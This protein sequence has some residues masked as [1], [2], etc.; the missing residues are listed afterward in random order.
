MDAPLT[1]DEPATG[2]KTE[3]TQPKIRT[4]FFFMGSN[5]SEFSS[6]HNKFMHAALRAETRDIEWV[7]RHA[8]G[9]QEDSC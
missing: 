5:G 8:E 7:R 3:V 9:V 1:V 4:A 2:N 6:N